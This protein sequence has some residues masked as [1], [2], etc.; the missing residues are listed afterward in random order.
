MKPNPPPGVEPRGAGQGE[1]SARHPVKDRVA[2]RKLGRMRV[3]GCA[4]RAIARR[5]VQIGGDARL[6]LETSPGEQSEAAQVAGGDGR[7]AVDLAAREQA[8]IMRFE[9]GGREV[10]GVEG[11][12]ARSTRP[13]RAS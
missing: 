7:F 5:P 1:G 9:I 3:N 13:S 10:E 6:A 12:F 4:Q 2:G 8:G 11:R